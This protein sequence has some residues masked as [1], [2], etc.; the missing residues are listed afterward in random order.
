MKKLILFY[1]LFCC[2]L[3][4]S[5]QGWKPYKID[6]SVQVSLPP[7]FTKTDTLGQTV[8]NA[9]TSFG[10]IVVTKQP[11]DPSTTPDIEKVKHLKSYYDD[12]VKRISS[13]SKGTVKDERDT[14]MGKLRIKEFTLEV[15][16]GS[17]K[18]FR[19]IRILHE[20]SATYTF[21]FLYKEIHADYARP[22]SEKFFGSIAMTENVGVKTQFTKPENTTG[23]SASGN[24]ML[25][26]GGGAAVIIIIVV[27]IIMSRRKRHRV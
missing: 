14:T 23:K 26:Y 21:Q 11:D 24:N 19:N 16:S 18:Q 25:L 12:F 20:N 17:G 3:S 10:N 7:G 15:D 22:E 2:A 4:A 6:D 27:I 13:T 1:T 9:S 8:I 5:A